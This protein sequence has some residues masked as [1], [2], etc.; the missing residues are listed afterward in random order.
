MATTLSE[1]SI[2]IRAKADGISA[3]IV[4]G[5]RSAQGAALAASKAL[6]VAMAGGATAAVGTMVVAFKNGVQQVDDLAAA[7]QKL[8]TSTNGLAALQYAAKLTDSSFESLTAGIAKMSAN[9]ATGA[10]SDAV[11][12]LNLNLAELR[13]LAPEQQFQRIAGALGA[14]GDKGAQLSLGKSIFGKGFLEIANL[15]QVGAEGLKKMVHEAEVFGLT[16][17]GGAIASI[18]EFDD[19]THR[20][21]GVWDGFGHQLAGEITPLMRG[22]GDEL[23]KQLESYGGMHVIVDQ[24]VHQLETNVQNALNFAQAVTMIPD[25][26][27]LLNEQLVG[28]TARFHQWATNGLATALRGVSALASAFEVMAKSVERQMRSVVNIIATL[29]SAMAQRI[30]DAFI[31]GIETIVNKARSAYSDVVGLWG[32][33][34]LA[35]ISLSAPQIG[36]LPTLDTA[37][38]PL[39]DATIGTGID[40]ISMLADKTE[41]VAD[42]FGDMSESAEQSAARIKDAYSDLMIGDKFKSWADEAHM[43]V[44]GMQ[45]KVK[46]GF[47]DVEKA[48]KQAKDKMSKSLKDHA[49]ETS[50]AFTE[51]QQSNRA[52]VGDMVTAWISGTGKMSD[53]INQW[54]QQSLRRIVDVLLF[55]TGQ[56]G[57][58]GGALGALGGGGGS[59]WGGAI[60]GVAGAL[61]GAGGGGFSSMYSAIPAGITAFA[62][63]GSFS[64][65]RPMLVGERGPEVI[66]PKNGGTVIPNG[67]MQGGGGGVA[68]IINVTQQFQVGVSRIE[69]AGIL[70]TL[71]ERTTAGVV[72]AYERGGSTR[73]RLRA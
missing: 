3:D 66:M 39:T 47:L 59:G 37:A 4:K 26:F 51:M 7:A 19:A 49:L 50:N 45:E 23:A 70:D 54:A 40:A 38:T 22:L 11:G 36:N 20:V 34:P 12:K 41:G 28:F 48:D 64:G 21:K 57:G 56:K 62:G 33:S 17:K 68:N 69:L 30:I 72:A 24:I 43:A 2:V 14:I 13:R 67:A 25:G 58:F 52:L 5:I 46:T 1:L 65:G 6:G 42:L 35:P 16:L 55:G 60:A 73:R 9:L 71:E 27:R 53:I 61:F 32:G 10:A 8:G 31:K 29:V 44:G 15:T 63:G 18:Q